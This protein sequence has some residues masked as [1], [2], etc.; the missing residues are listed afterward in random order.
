[1]GAARLQPPC[2]WRFKP[3]PTV[4]GLKHCVPASE[5]PAHRST[6][7]AKATSPPRRAPHVMSFVL[8]PLFAYSY[9]SAVA[10]PLVK[11]GISVRSVLT[12]RC[13]SRFEAACAESHMS[14]RQSTRNYRV[15]GCCGFKNLFP[16]LSMSLG[17][18]LI[19]RP[20]SDSCHE[21]VPK[22]AIRWPL[23][24]RVLECGVF[25]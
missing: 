2:R 3:L 19:V 16:R 10:Y 21:I 24:A 12:S 23:V 13:R 6:D 5:R 14:G 11:F 9:P 7:H 22:V 25:F 8:P 20:L 17:V 4:L 1:M 18:A 15:H